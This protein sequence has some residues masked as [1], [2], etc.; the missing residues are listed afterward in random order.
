MKRDWYKD[1]NLYDVGGRRV[2]YRVD[3][4]TVTKV[5][6]ETD[7]GERRRGDRRRRKSY[8]EDP[9][10]LFGEESDYYYDSEE[11]EESSNGTR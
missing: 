10:E 8:Y 6:V 11:E 9:D 2:H 3:G 1:K 5:E 4:N 7:I